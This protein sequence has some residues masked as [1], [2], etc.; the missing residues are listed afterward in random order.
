M[1]CVRH[2]LNRSTEPYRGEVFQLAGG[3]SLRWDIF[4]PDI[5]FL[6]GAWGRKTIEA[7][8][9]Q[10]TEIKIGGTANPK[11][12]ARMR[13]EAARLGEQAGRTAD[14]VSIVVGAV[15]VIDNDGG[16]ARDLARRQVALYLPVVAPLDATLEIDPALLARVRR[17]AER[18]DFD[19]AARDISDA[20]LRRLAFAGTPGEIA[21]HAIELFEAGA[22]RIEFG[23]PHGLTEEEGLRLLGEKVL[24][25]LRQWVSH[26]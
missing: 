17:A 20:L 12:A 15:T 25:A 16:A 26:D 13:N 19:A 23:T 5:P 8:I 7:C 22:G 18:Y 1:D 14:E 11:I 3:D 6:L 10:V 9:G 2:L 4:R 24:P 21:A